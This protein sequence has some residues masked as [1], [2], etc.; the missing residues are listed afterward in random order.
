M[1]IATT[2]SPRSVVN[3]D[4]NPTM[5]RSSHPVLVTGMFVIA[6]LVVGIIAFERQLLALGVLDKHNM[7]GALVGGGVGAFLIVVVAIAALM[8][9]A[10]NL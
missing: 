8:R 4:H 1:S 7:K 3:D 9:E 5:H 10:R 6:P 2:S